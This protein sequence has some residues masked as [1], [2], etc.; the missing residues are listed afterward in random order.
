MVAALAANGLKQ[1]LNF[2]PNHMG[3]GGSD[4]PLWLDV[5][6]WGQNSDHAGWFDID[7]DPD[8]RYLHNKLLI[9]SLGDQ[10]A[11]ALDAG[12][13]SPQVRCRGRD[14]RGMGL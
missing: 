12:S 2:V 1:V 10:Y 8:Q 14:L 4:N 11:V 6:E 5:L 7:W 9:P 3:V 13:P